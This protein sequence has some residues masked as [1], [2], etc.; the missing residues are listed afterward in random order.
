MGVIVEAGLGEAA[1]GE[2]DEGAGE[3]HGSGRG[4][5]AH[6]RGGGGHGRG[7]GVAGVGERWRLAGWQVA[8]LTRGVLP[9][10]GFGSGVEVRSS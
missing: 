6:G 5:R 8:D 9:C 7:R 2:E 10:F 1:E 3:R 4:E